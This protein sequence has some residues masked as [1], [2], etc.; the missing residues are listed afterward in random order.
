MSG[1]L[2]EWFADYLSGRCQRV[3]IDGVVSSWAPVTSGVAQGSIL[4]PVLFALFINDLPNVLPDE[5]MAALYA[6][7]TKV[8]KSIRSTTTTTTTTIFIR[9]ITYNNYEINKVKNSMIVTG[10]LK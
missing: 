6:D 7:D 10:N 4:G 1:H 9:T 3:A 5:T 8:Y 2:H